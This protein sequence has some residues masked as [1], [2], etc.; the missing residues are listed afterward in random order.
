M[1]RLMALPLLTLSL[2]SNAGTAEH[3]IK[4]CLPSSHWEIMKQIVQKES[5]SRKYA[6]GI[7]QK[8]YK[9]RYPQTMEQARKDVEELL[10]KG[11]SFG[12]GYAQVD[13][14][15]FKKGKLFAKR[16]YTYED[17]LDPCTNLKMGALIFS[18][19]YRRF[20]NVP[21]ALSAYNTGSPTKGYKNGYVARY[22]KN[23]G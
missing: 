10:S 2:A 17:A 21:D 16:G 18:D 13:S 12:I 6:L 19:F 22:V 5:S 14:Q 7:N 8:G 4:K 3:Y 9:S 11:L 20:G 23:K 1:K 15:H